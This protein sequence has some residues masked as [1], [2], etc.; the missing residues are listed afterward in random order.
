MCMA[1]AVTGC[2]ALAFDVL[3]RAKLTL[4]IGLVSNVGEYLLNAAVNKLIRKSVRLIE[5]K[6]VV[7]VMKACKRI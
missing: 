2:L 1:R 4:T 7:D 5:R 6:D 3:E